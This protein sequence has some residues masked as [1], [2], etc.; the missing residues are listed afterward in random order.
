MFELYD[1]VRVKKEY[2][3]LSLTPNN[4]GTI[5][6]IHNGGK[7]YTVEFIDENFE[8]IEEALYREFSESELEKATI[9][10]GLDLPND[11]AERNA[12]IMMKQLG[13]TKEDIENCKID[14]T[15]YICN[16]DNVLEQLIAIRNMTDEEFDKY[17]CEVLKK[18]YL[19]FIIVDENKN[20]IGFKSDTPIENYM[21]HC[22]KAKKQQA[23]TYYDGH[24]EESKLSLE[25]IEKQLEEEK[26]KVEQMTEWEGI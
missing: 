23:N 3:E 16:D 8:T 18:E 10:Y 25:E 9:I 17:Q 1:I 21:K 22:K 19:P 7:A 15:D 5:V 12:L 26:K 4:I 6:D 20:I 14:D 11:V 2:P 24:Y 13:I